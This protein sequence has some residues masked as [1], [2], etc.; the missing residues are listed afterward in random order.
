MELGCDAMQGYL[1]SKP[2]PADEIERVLAP[3]YVR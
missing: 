2:L 1:C 3:S